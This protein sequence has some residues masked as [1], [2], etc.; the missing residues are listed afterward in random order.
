MSMHLSMNKKH[1]TYVRLVIAALL[2]GAA[3]SVAAQH[4]LV[5]VELSVF[6]L[7]NNLPEFLRAPMWLATQLG[8]VWFLVCLVILEVH[9]R[10]KQFALRL[11]LNGSAA[12]ILTELL[13]RVIGRARPEYLV[14]GVHVRELFVSGLGFP[15]GHATMATIAA[16]TLY[17]S[18]AKRYRIWL[19]VW[20]VSVMISRVYLGVH[21]PLDVVAG[22][23]VGVL[24]RPVVDYAWRQFRP[25]IVYKRM[26]KR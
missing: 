21:A 14:S 19:Y 18:V 15:S 5:G 9:R 22:V 8:S 23:C 4:T 11:L 17:S 7:I 3:T 20:V 1:R 6:R 12:Y 26:R 25:L 13:K 10:R 2:F 24:M 16:L